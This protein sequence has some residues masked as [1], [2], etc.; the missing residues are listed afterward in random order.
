[1]EKNELKK[2]LYLNKPTAYLLYIRKG[3]AYYKCN[4]NDIEIMFDIPVTDMGD[5]DFLPE[6]EAKLLARWIV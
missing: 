1:M 5:A 2:L 4:V 6:M 3:S